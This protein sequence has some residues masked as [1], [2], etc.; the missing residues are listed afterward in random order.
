MAKR[1]TDIRGVTKAMSEYHTYN[2]AIEEVK[3]LK[4][5]AQRFVQ[6]IDDE[7]K[8]LLGAMEMM[9]EGEK[10]VL[11]EK[12]I[13]LAVM[14]KKALDVL[15]SL[16]V[17]LES[18]VWKHVLV[19]LSCNQENLQPDQSHEDYPEFEDT[20]MDNTIISIEEFEEYGESVFF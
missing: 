5:E 20:E 7:L 8:Q 13:S 6:N 3:F 17:S 9:N 18:P 2:R 16:S 15:S 11:F 1:S 19:E 14:Q 12:K 4:E 10:N